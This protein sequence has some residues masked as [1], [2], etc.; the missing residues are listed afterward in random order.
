LPVALDEYFPHHKKGN[1]KDRKN[2]S[3]SNSSDSEDS[4]DSEFDL[5]PDIELMEVKVRTM[6]PFW[7]LPY[8]SHAHFMYTMSW[9]HRTPTCSTRA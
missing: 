5:D 4:E 8:C 2:D 3:E 7:Q 1:G 6:S 9:P